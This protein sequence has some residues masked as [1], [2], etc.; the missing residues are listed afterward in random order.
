MRCA[1]MTEQIEMPFG[2]WTQVD[3]KK[4]VLD[5]VHIG[6]TWRIRLNHPCAAAMR[7]FCQIALTTCWIVDAVFRVD[8]YIA[9]TVTTRVTVELFLS[10]SALFINRN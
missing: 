5:G 7:P 2:L 1:K 6:A 8:F 3:P 10:V 4:N 9:P